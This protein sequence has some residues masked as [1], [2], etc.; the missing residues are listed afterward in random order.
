M[1]ERIHRLLG[2]ADRAL[3]GKLHPDL[4]RSLLLLETET[5][6]ATAFSRAAATAA[7]RVLDPTD[8]VSWEFT[9]FSQHG[10]DGVI[11]YLCS[12]LKERNRFF[13]EI[14]SADGLENCTAWLAFARGYGGVM[15]EGN[16]V[17]SGRCRAMLEGRVW[18]VQAVNLMVD[19]DNISR[20]MKMC[21][22]RE[23][24]VFI[25]DIDGID[26]YVAEEVLELGFRPKIFVA[27]YNSSFG[28]ERAVT[29]P[30]RPTFSRWESHPTGLHYGA[31]IAAWRA[32]LGRY[33]Y[34]FVSVESSGTNAF[35][36][37]PARFPDGF[38]DAL[39]GVAFRDNNGDLNG[40]TRPYRDDRGDL[41][42]PDR[43]WRSQLGRLED[44]KLV[45]V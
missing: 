22:A 16:P 27:E 2:R 28:P 26:Y 17:L 40:A 44:A 11:D 3:K 7:A 21:P 39:R 34:R 1:R 31:S 14:G 32:L 23:P 13:F 36:L 38:A 43:D 4:E 15:V 30:Y 8:P 12:R 18:N 10:E 35:F 25:I 20:L 6:M 45:E 9:G 29:I 41:V 19:K 5:R 37:D 24:D 42:V 33:G